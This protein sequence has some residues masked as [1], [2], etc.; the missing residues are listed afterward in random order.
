MIRSLR[1]PAL[2]LG[3]GLFLT[4]SCQESGTGDNGNQNNDTT[5]A[6]APATPAAPIAV[7]DV[8]ASPEFADAQLAIAKVNG[9]PAGDSTKVSFDFSVKNYELKNQTADAASKNCN[10]SAQGQHIHFILD[11][12]PY[13][14]LY[15]PKHEVTLAK[16]TEH[17]LMCFLSRSYHE[18]LKNKGAAVVYHFKIDEQGKLQ[19]LAD[20][21]EPMLFYSRPKGDYLGKD[22]ANLLLDFYVWNANLGSDYQ[23]KA[24]FVNEKTG[25]TGSYTFTEWKP[26]FI[27]NLGTG[28]A[29]VTLSL[30]DKDGKPVNE[31]MNKITRDIRLAA[32]EPM[33]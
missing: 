29:K 10:N 18:A 15:E 20:P 12:K 21:K 25:Q 26:K 9:V 4:T 7:T 5:Q 6:S 33:Q 24:D 11:N 8:P 31:S 13:V 32:Q 17:Y 30:V 19:K 1:I 23:V 22:T 27:Q 16:N 3:T 14:A 2:L 28:N